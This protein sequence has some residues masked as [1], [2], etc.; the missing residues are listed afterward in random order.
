MA[1]VSGVDSPLVFGGSS[2]VG[3]SLEFPSGLFAASIL[4]FLIF[5]PNYPLT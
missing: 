2:V 4:L 5:L 3:W 1:N